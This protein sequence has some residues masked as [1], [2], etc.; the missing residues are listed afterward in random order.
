MF[1]GAKGSRLAV[2]Q[3]DMDYISFGRGEK[4]LLILPGL[5]D[6][7]KTVRGTAV[8]FAFMYRALSQAFRVVVLSRRN[9]L[10]EGFSTRDMAD[11]AAAALRTLGIKKA[12]VLGVSQGGM[13]AQMLALEHPE[14]VERLILAVTSS[15][16]NDTLISTVTEFIRLAEKRDYRSLMK[17]TS[18][19]TYSE[20]Y[21]KR[22]RPFYPL[23][24]SF[25][26]PKDYSRFF[27]NARACLTHDCFD[28]LSRISVPTL[29]LGGKEDRIVT[30]QASVELAE[31]IAGSELICYDNF[32]HGLYEEAADFLPR[33]I[34]FCTE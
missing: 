19:K 22:V 6:G 32:G 29:I 28:R 4:F 13:I 27:V 12:C 20:N 26:A 24:F 16:P 18:E 30:M 9:E 11:D 7:L 31:R 2:G 34:S 1:Y 33:I 17:Y 5:S 10:P 14:C 23:I 3:S 15:R 21:L 8:A 25:G